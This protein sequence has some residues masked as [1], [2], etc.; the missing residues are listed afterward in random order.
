MGAAW[1]PAGTVDGLLHDPTV[2]VLKKTVED[3]FRESG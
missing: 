1:E 2:A 3:A